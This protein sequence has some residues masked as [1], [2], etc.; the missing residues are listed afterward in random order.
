MLL[1]M[2]LALW[3]LFALPA[4]AQE[5]APDQ[6]LDAP[7]D[8]PTDQPS[9]ETIDQP[10]IADPP[11]APIAPPADAELPTSPATP[12]TPGLNEPLQSAEEPPTPVVV[13]ANRP[14][15][16][17][18]PPLLDGDVHRISV[19][20]EFQA[21]EDDAL[22]AL[23]NELVKATRAYVADRLGSSK[24]PLFFSYSIDEIKRRFTKPDNLYHEV[25]T[26]SF[27]S[28]HQY[29][30]VLE[31]PQDFRKEIYDRWAQVRAAGN[32][33]KIGGGTVGIIAL[34][35][36]LFGYF[37]LDTATRGYYTSRLQ[38]LVALAI[39]ALIVAGGIIGGPIAT[40]LIVST[41]LTTTKSLTS[42]RPYVVVGCFVVGMML[43]PG[44]DVISQIML[45]VPMWILFELGVFF[46]RMAER[47]TQATEVAGVAAKD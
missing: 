32:L 34:L 4:R 24:A 9:N 18:A 20:S 25:G 27:G 30:T 38:F 22:R 36:I 15:W 29:H 7:V 10:L 14:D 16:I 5:V 39:L 26:F 1:G 19:R 12:S 11:A 17:E 41:G 21:R 43:T 23:D 31:F 47:N 8:Q 37:R 28:M 13:A 3:T 45:A 35:V 42:K 40:F 2:G 6:S 44:P 46:A 33:V